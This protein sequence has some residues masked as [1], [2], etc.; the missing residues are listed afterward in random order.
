MHS[1]T[2]S[3]TE[4]CP[5]M[6]WRG[7]VAGYTC[8]ILLGLCIFAVSSY[9]ARPPVRAQSGRACQAAPCFR[10]A[11]AWHKKEERH[12]RRQL[13]VKW[14]PTLTWACKVGQVVYGVPVEHCKRVVGCESG[15]D[16]FQVTPPFSASGLSQFLP[17][18]WAGTAFGRAGFSVFDPVAPVLQ[19]DA[20]AKGQG[21]DTGYGWAAS[22]YCHGL[23]GPEG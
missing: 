23:S 17:S 13:A 18:T 19:M 3:E 15:G 1:D 2:R 21:F 7:V 9:A 6:S 20:I 11:L 16:R 12:L 8:L 14:A 5:R 4:Y 10:R 22:H